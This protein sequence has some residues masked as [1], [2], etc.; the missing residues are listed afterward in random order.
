MTK[1][2]SYDRWDQH[3]YLVDA[4]NPILKNATQIAVLWSCFRNGRGL[5]YFRVS[6]PRIAKCSRTST[7]NVQRII[8]KFEGWGLIEL[9]APQRGTTPKTYRIR[10][11]YAGEQIFIPHSIAIETEKCHKAK[12]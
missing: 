7:R 2:K 9:V 6:T 5:G 11:T 4:I 10:F 8:D 1:R 12:T 3:N